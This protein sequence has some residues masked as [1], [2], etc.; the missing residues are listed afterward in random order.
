MQSSL[1]SVLLSYGDEVGD[2]GPC[3]AKSTDF[4]DE[5]LELIVSCDDECCASVATDNGGGD[6]NS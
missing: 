6:R 1:S 3:A 5:R 2:D 4:W